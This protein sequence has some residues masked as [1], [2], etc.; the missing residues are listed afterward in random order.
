MPRIAARKRRG[1][2]KRTR[3]RLT[4]PRRSSIRASALSLAGHPAERGNPA[5]RTL[6]VSY[7]ACASI[8]E[9]SRGGGRLFLSSIEQAPRLVDYKGSL[10]QTPLLSLL[11]SMQAQ[12]AT[13]TLQVRSGG[14]AF[15]LFF[16]FG[17]LF[18]AYG[19]GS[20]GEEAVFEPLAW[21]QGD[22]TFDPKSKLPTEETITA[23]TADIL[24]EAKRRGVPG[25]DNGPAPARGSAPAQA[26]AHTTSAPPQPQ[27]SERPVV[28]QPAPAAQP[29]PAPEEGPPPTELYPLPVGKLVYE[30]LKTAFVDFPKLLRSLSADRLT[31]DLRLTGQAS[32]GMILFYQGSLIESF[33]DGGAVVTTGRTAFSLFKNDVD[34]GEGSMDVIELSAEVVTAIYQ[35]LTA[36]TILQG[37]LARFVDVRALLQYLQEEK[38]HGSLLVRAPD[39]MGIVLLRD[40]QLLGAFTRGQPQLMQDPEIV[41]RLCADSKTRIEVKAVADLEEPASV[42]LEEMLAMTPSVPSTV[43]RP[44]PAPVQAGPAAQAQATQ[45]IPNYQPPPQPAQGPAAGE[46]LRAQPSAHRQHLAWP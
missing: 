2:A 39:E 30:S 12:R 3:P 11:Q 7:L 19:N 16:L 24:A 25:A 14:E 6:G 31:G 15:S 32:R 46:R 40:G 4:H 27:V 38:I 33:Y 29:T 8:G 1:P 35:L 18:H 23:P 10:D 22:Y 9:K 21:R 34:R 43:Y 20:Q 5:S 42:S 37:L 45:R 36:P 41:T 17:H 13:G 26:A 28:S 44:A